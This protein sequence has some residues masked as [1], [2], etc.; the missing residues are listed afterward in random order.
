MKKVITF[1][2]WGNNKNYTIGAIK[3]AKIALYMY[4]EFECW[5]Y[6]H[7]ETVPEE[8]INELRSLSNTNIILKSGDLNTCKPMMWRFE[9][10]DNDDVEVMMSRDTDTRIL[11]REKLAVYE[12]LKSE[13]IFHIMRDHPH[14]NFEIL[15]GM[16]GTRK[17]PQVS[18]WKE[19]M[20]TIIQ[21]SE[22]AYDQW[23]LKEYIYEHIKSNALIH[24]IFN[25]YEENCIP[26]PIPYDNDFKF[27]GEYVYE[28]NTRSM[29][30]IKDLTNGLVTNK[31]HLITSFYIINK[32]EEK[33]TDEKITQRNNELLECL[34]HNLNND[35]VEKIHLY[36]DDIKSLNSAIQM[37]K[38]NKIIII[39]VGKQP[40]YYEMFKY[41][42][43]NL[44]NSICMISNSDIYLYKCD[45]K[46]LS[47]L[48]NNIFA[49]SRHEYN[50]KCEVLGWGSHDA[51]IFKP[52]YL[53]YEILQGMNHEQ[54]VAGSD[55]NIVNILCD[56]GFKLYN[57]CFE[58]MLIHLHSSNH[59]TYDANKIA[60]GK[61]FIK[62]EY[63]IIDN[64]IND[65]IDDDFI[66]YN[67]LDHFGDDIYLKKS[68]PI[69]QLKAICKS[70]INCVGFNTLGF[71]KNK[72]DISNLKE[73]T[74]INKNTRHG[75][76]VKKN[77]ISK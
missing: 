20:N 42:I 63:F 3:N 47:K 19:I 32:T 77:I 68:Y 73:T 72:I 59:R 75:I 65:N 37:D 54:N 66:F 28:D 71:F 56:N 2:L 22:K 23:F 29:P 50:L 34:Y 45:L 44:N 16:F 12:W 69:N 7:K 27:V 40:T 39:G 4:P 13:K 14:H 61:Y 58:I 21:N 1:S 30:H 31:I 11:L 33:I 6:I 74:W 48:E 49:L 15:G 57:P 51:F 76:F 25:K 70:D 67:G 18:N 26:F 43:D 53:S 8:I 46:V 52:C 36:V 60:N 55:D 35:L 64:Y 5:F 41:S 62:Q 38:Y 10:I 17:I 9:A 24:A